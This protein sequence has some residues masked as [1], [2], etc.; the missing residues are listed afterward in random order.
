MQ[1]SRIPFPDPSFNQ[2]LPE[3]ND[4]RTYENKFSFALFFFFLYN[5]EADT[6]EL[7]VG[8]WQAFRYTGAVSVCV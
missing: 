3:G 6:G 7:A 1:E 8:V 2:I 5:T 4:S